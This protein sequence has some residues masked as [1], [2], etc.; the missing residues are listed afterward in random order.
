[1]LN[2]RYL[3]TARKIPTSSSNETTGILS[4]ETER[5]DNK[6]ASKLGKSRLLQFFAGFTSLLLTG[7]TGY[8]FLSNG[9]Q[10]SS[11]HGR[12]VAKKTILKSERNPPLVDNGIVRKDPLTIKPL[13]V[14]IDSEE[15][16]EPKEPEESEESRTSDA[17]KQIDE[18][19][20]DFYK[21]Y[22]G[23]EEANTLLKKGVISFGGRS[24]VYKHMAHRF[25]QAAA[26][27]VNVKFSFG[28]Y[29]VTV[30]RGNHFSQSYPFVVQ[31][32]L[33]DLILDIWNIELDVKNAA[34]GGIP[35]LPYGW[36]LKNFLGDD[37]DLVSWDYGM[38]EGSTTHALESYLRHS[39]TLPNKPMFLMLDVN[40]RRKRILD[41]YVKSG[42]IV[43]PVAINKDKLVNP[44]FLQMSN[45][46]RPEGYKDWEKWGSPRG[47]PGQ[48]RWH[49]RYKEHELIGWII[50][51]HILDGIKAAVEIMQSD[52][53]WETTFEPN[54]SD[55]QTVLM[56]HVKLPAPI[57]KET[58]AGLESMLYGTLVSDDVKN[59]I[60]RMNHVSCRT[61]F[62][63]SVSGKMD[64]IVVSGTT[65]LV[66]DD[67][68][69][70]R[71][72]TAYEDG[73]VMDIGKVE[74]DTKRKVEKV[75][76]MGY[77]DMKLAYYGIPQSGTLSLWLPYEGEP[78]PHEHK[79]EDHEIAT[80]YFN[81][82]IIICE[83]N[84]KRQSKFHECDMKS[85]V[86]FTIGG[87]PSKRVIPIKSVASYLGKNIC[88]QVEIPSNAKIT[89]KTDLHTHTDNNK[90]N[91]S[92]RKSIAVT[93][94]HIRYAL[95]RLELARLESDE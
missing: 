87:E 90:N 33:N 91:T 15:F 82:H 86:S 79:E 48:S 5:A 44:I 9:I 27:N 19:K 55:H 78:H 21:R 45:E 53:N 47:S 71:N 65:N 66:D 46:E 61:T 32:V 58:E 13:P 34:I 38:N 94:S 16:E 6:K 35:S 57:S 77:I 83:V 14:S 89:K 37:S 3:S 36:C 12:R 51:M 8:F 23:K 20:E 42:A 85:D 84:E 4:H 7:F 30:G 92:R 49:P 52:E 10:H 41:D 60:W 73:W 24:E 72:D 22:G 2:R 80:H 62:L 17:L 40:N 69:T 64:S 67:P 93:F 95:T 81:K 29:S 31:R 1:M 25:L 74:R 88:I 54:S 26:K 76:G 70:E 18:L 50:A 28:G 11:S 63:P 59:V 39:M 68:M 75:G 43:D 56:E